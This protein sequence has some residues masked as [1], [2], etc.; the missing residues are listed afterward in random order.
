MLSKIAQVLK[1][2]GVK[3]ALVAQKNRDF[4]LTKIEKAEQ[5]IKS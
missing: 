1:D 4:I 5:A 3:N 2:T